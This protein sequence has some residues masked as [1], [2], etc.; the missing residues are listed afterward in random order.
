MPLIVFGGPDVGGGGAGFGAPPLPPPPQPAK[1]TLTT[2]S[3]ALLMVVVCGDEFRQSV[4]DATSVMLCPVFGY[5][6][7]INTTDRDAR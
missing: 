1:S 5:S 4:R 6:S 2:M 3:Q 7:H